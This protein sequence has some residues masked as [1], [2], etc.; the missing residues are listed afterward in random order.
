M[1]DQVGV[2]HSTYKALDR[3]MAR[4]MFVVLVFHTPSNIMFP[5]ACIVLYLVSTWLTGPVVMLPIWRDSKLQLQPQT[6][7]WMPE[8]CSHGE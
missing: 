2:V 4:L 3:G 6:V 5:I 7:G 1:V 8:T